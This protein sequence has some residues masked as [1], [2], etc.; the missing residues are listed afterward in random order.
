M[1]GRGWGKDE[2]AVHSQH[3]TLEVSLLL[4]TVGT[5]RADKLWSFTTF[6]LQMVTKCAQVSIGTTTIAL[7]KL[8]TVGIRHQRVVWSVVCN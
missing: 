8:F 5:V 7:V 6:K 4:G 2:L 3:V 1:N